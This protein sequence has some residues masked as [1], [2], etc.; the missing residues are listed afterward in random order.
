[1]LRK[2]L[3]HFSNMGW[4]FGLFQEDPEAYLKEQK[5]EGL[6]KLNLSEEEI[7][8]LI[9]DRNGARK[10]KNWKRGDEIRSDL[11]SKGIVLEDTPSGTIWKIK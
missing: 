4:I 5:I 6:K 7:L 2:G 1:M 3:N 9:E 10:E 11:L 8:R